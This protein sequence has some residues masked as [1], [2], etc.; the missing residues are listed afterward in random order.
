MSH[1]KERD[2]KICL[3][4][5]TEVVGRYCH[6][7]G[8]ENR[9]PKETVWGLIN[10]F[11][12]DITH[13][14]SKFFS[15]VRYLVSKPGF[16]PKEYITGR[17]ASYINPIRLYI[18][19]SAIFFII[20]FS[21]FDPSN[22]NY[23]NN[24]ENGKA[25][26]TVTA[27]LAYAKEQALKEA[28]NRADSQAIERAFAFTNLPLP[29][30]V[31]ID[32]TSSRD[33]TNRKKRKM[34][35]QKDSTDED[36]DHTNWNF[37]LD[38]SNFSSREQYDSIQNSLPAEKRDGWWKRKA[39][40]RSIELSKRF[41]DNPQQLWKDL[42]NKFVHSFPYLLFVSLPLYA[43]FLKL[44]YIRRKFYYVDHGMFL[45]YLYVFTFLFLLVWYGIIELQDKLNWGWM[46]FLQAAFIIYGI[47][48][49]YRAMYKFY[50]QG[51][52]KTFLKFFL[53]NIISF[54]SI[55]ILF[56]IFFTLTLFRI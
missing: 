6:I 17:R 56:T 41:K 37:S 2:E 46:G 31:N 9:E 43:L 19:S 1:F 5:K 53:F 24:G 3:N 45:I 18:F 20:F 49:A 26:D 54:F 7:C 34:R 35:V 16:L 39:A 51:H 13:F 23:N 50:G 33:S 29:V 22:M 14:D 44:I 11:F 40:Y 52:G 12:S 21:V 4:C 47:Y 27:R 10:H 32:S 48:Y 38:N 28:E 30:T 42:I 15:T 55:I 8:Q 25:T 36:D